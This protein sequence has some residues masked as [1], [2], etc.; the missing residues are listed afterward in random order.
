[1]AASS[2]AD[3]VG[4][5]P[6]FWFYKAD[7]SAAAHLRLCEVAR[8]Y[9][10]PEGAARLRHFYDVCTSEDG[11][12]SLR[13]YYYAVTNYVKTHPLAAVVRPNGSSTD[14][15]SVASAYA[16][17]M[18]DY[19]S[20]LFCAFRRGG[21]KVQYLLPPPSPTAGDDGAAAAPRAQVETTVGQLVFYWWAVTHGVDAL[22]RTHNDAIRYHEATFK[23]R[24]KAAKEAAP[25]DERGKRKRVREVVPSNKRRTVYGM[26][27]GECS[28]VT[29]GD[30]EVDAALAAHARRAAAVAAAAA[31]ATSAARD[32]RV[33]TEG[34][35]AAATRSPE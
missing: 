15:V 16:V 1:M 25:V 5:Q 27:Y 19:G 23:A 34:A 22:V 11:G 4:K 30:A 13:R 9:R 3:P 29:D 18:D 6:P 28:L 20:D 10:G 8:W 21:Y 12:P 31:A 2:H 7:L 33:D 35:R 32:A 14:L 26:A 17:A 24:S